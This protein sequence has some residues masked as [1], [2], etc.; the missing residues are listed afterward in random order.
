LVQCLGSTSGA[1][2][3]LIKPLFVAVRAAR[4]QAR[5]AGRAFSGEVAILAEHSTPYR[6]LSEVLYTAG[7]AELSR[8]CLVVRG[9][10]GARHCRW[11]IAV[12]YASPSDV[13]SAPPSEEEL[14]LTAAVTYSGFIVAGAGQVL[15]APDGKMP[16]VKCAAPLQ[17]KR[18][19]AHLDQSGKRP[20]WIDDYDYPALAEILAKIKK[21]Y[22]V[23]RK[24]TISADDEIL[25][26]TIIRTLD[27]V[28]GTQTH[29]CS[30][31]NGCMFDQFTLIVGGQ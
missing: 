21:R 20:R 9:K 8:P 25:Y 11:P 18:C 14:N 17:Q 30:G 26:Q 27:T 10:G 3:Y 22:P 7:Q 31:T 19:P 4:A 29:S 15:V 5:K 13:P 24:V 16:T 23:D 12:K 6:L 1:T 28:W 2:G